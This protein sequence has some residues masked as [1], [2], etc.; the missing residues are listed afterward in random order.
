MTKT[1]PATDSTVRQTAE[2][3]A[4]VGTD[5]TARHHE[6]TEA[7]GGDASLVSERGAFSLGA[8]TRSAP[9]RQERFAAAVIQRIGGWD[10]TYGDADSGGAIDWWLQR[11]G[12]RV[13]G[14]E[15]TV[16]GDPKLL[17]A[18]SI[19]GDVHWDLP[20]AKWRWM[21]SYSGRMQVR[22]ARS[23]LRDLIVLC[24]AE[25]VTRPE[26][27]GWDHRDET[28]V[29]W[30]RG[31]GCSL[32]GF[33]GATSGGVVDVLPKGGGGFML[34][35][36]TCL[37]DWI[38][39]ELDCGLARKVRRFDEIQGPE[40]HLFVIVH[41]SGMPMSHFHHLAFSEGLP[42]REPDLPMGLSGLWLLPNWGSS[43]L[44][45]HRGRGWMRADYADVVPTDA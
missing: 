45:W 10:C 29:R 18:M 17:E 42:T 22:S 43:V 44:W 8:V 1:P 33:R 38:E 3:N 28:C 14:V 31:S 6:A 32:H 23:H 4:A 41:D 25:G 24:E 2:G 15:V 16:V 9:T 35:D 36:P 26:D 39:Q 30:Y 13:G 21:L 5:R 7:S 20:E 34:E 11:D 12:C 19:V 37:T 27:L 40:R